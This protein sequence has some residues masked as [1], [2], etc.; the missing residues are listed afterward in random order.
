VP[1]GAEC[2]NNY[3]PKPNSELILGYGFALPSN[4]DDTILLSLAMSDSTEASMIEVGREAKNGDRLWELVVSKVTEMYDQEP[5]EED[6]EEDR[7]WEIELEAAET[8]VSLTEGRIQRLPKSN[9][10]AEGVRPE[11]G[12]M[13]ECY[14]E[15]VYI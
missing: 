12:N 11:V 13:V 14:L 10:T 5:G 2:F 9:G 7:S 1:A 4:P 15:G 3:G 8:I 6:G